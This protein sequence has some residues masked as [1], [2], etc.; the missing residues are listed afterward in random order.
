MKNIIAILILIQSVFSVNMNIGAMPGQTDDFD[1]TGAF[2]HKNLAI[3]LI[4]DKKSKSHEILTLGEALEKKAAVVYETGNVNELFVE[5]LATVDVYIQAGDIVKGG[6]QDR[7]LAMD[8]IL[9]PNSGKIAISSFCVEQGRWAKRSG[10]SMLGFSSSAMAVSSKNLRLAVKRDKRQGEVWK[11]VAAVQAELSD[12]FGEEVAYSQVSRTSLVLSLESQKITEAIDKYIE[13]L[14]GVVED[15]EDVVG[16]AFAINGELN[17]ADIYS[18]Y[19]LFR[20]L[21]PKLLKACA[22]EAIAASRQNGGQNT[23]STADVRAFLD[24]VDNG[25]RTEKAVSERVNLITKET[26]TTILF[27]TEDVNRKG[28]WVHRNYIMK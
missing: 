4:H 27:E 13:K 6:K 25:R 11:E 23:V 3:F 26:D 20:K 21:W 7:V 24:G 16:F 1:I 12:S 14:K 2:T 5:N 18:S 8:L 15:R 9:P 10:E 17:S 22:T 19:D 28:R